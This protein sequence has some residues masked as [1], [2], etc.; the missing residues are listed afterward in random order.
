VLRIEGRCRGGRGRSNS[1]G[2]RSRSNSAGAR[3]PGGDSE[4]ET[5]TEEVSR[6]SV[7]LG[8]EGLLPPYQPVAEDTSV[9]VVDKQ[10]WAGGSSRSAP[11]QPAFGDFE[12]A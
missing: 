11:G 9:N 5:E 1:V 6:L 12:L 2:V 7:A 10:G 4:T 3:S 8:W